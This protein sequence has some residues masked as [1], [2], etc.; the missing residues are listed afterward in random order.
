MAEW[1]PLLRL[2]L[3]ELPQPYPRIEIAQRQG[4]AVGRQRQAVI[5]TPSRR[6]CGPQAGLWAVEA[7]E[8]GG[9][10]YADRGEDLAVL[11]EGYSINATGMALPLDP[12]ARRF[13]AQVPKSQQSA[14]LTDRHQALAIR[15]EDG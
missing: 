1:F 2:V 6:K 3:V 13:F 8:L 7:P 14:T 12:L 10:E 11:G 15:G 4:L 5:I 9:P